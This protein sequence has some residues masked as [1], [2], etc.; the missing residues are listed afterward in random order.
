ME[1]E[2]EVLFWIINQKL[3]E[4]IEDIDRDTLFEYINTK[5]FL[6][7]VFCTYNKIINLRYQSILL[8]KKFNIFIFR[9]DDQE[10]P[11]SPKILRHI[12]LIDDEA[13]EYGI[14]IVKCNDML[15]AKKY[16]FR[17]PP[18]ITYFRKSKFYY[19]ASLQ[20]FEKILSLL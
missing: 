17:N 4:S 19:I 7:V 3:D 20:N 18:G 8:I 11:I 5:D 12:E 2:E 6:A 1:N 13:A 10:D 14:K 9:I 16:G 15:M